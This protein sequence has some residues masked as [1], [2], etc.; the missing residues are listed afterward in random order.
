ML[1]T[2]GQQSYN[3]VWQSHS[4][5]NVTNT[6]PPLPHAQI[7]QLAGAYNS[8]LQATATQIVFVMAVI[9]GIAVLVLLVALFRIEG[10]RTTAHQQDYELIKAQ[11]DINKT[12]VTEL[13]KQSGALTLIERHLLTISEDTRKALDV[14]SQRVAVHEINRVNIEKV[15]TTQATSQAELL[16]RFNDVITK[17]DEAL[18]RSPVITREEIQ[19]LDAKLSLILARLQMQPDASPLLPETVKVEVKSVP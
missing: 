14:N 12:Q 19:A 2:F 6:S 3:F 10:S 1:D 4:F 18:A 11:S 13:Q 16:A 7:D 8:T 15:M 9:V 17:L 5:V